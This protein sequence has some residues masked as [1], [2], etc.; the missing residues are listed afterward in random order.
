MREQAHRSIFCLSALLLASWGCTGQPLS[1][2]AQA[3][4]TILIPLSVDALADLTLSLEHVGYG[5]SPGVPGGYKDPQRGY[6]E[7]RLEQT[8]DVLVTRRAFLTEHTLGSSLAELRTSVGRTLI[9][10]VDIPIDAPHGRFDLELWHRRWNPEAGGGAGVWEENRALAG[11]T[12]YFGTLAILPDVLTVNGETI[13][14]APTPALYASGDG[15]EYSNAY[16]NLDSAVP[17]PSIEI[18]IQDS[19]GSSPPATPWVSSAKVS[20]SYPA[21]EI[22]ILDVVPVEPERGRVFYWDNPARG[23]LH[24]EAMA[25]SPIVNATTNTWFNADELQMSPIRVVFEP[26]NPGVALLDLIDVDATLDVARD[27][28]GTDLLDHGRNISAEAK[29]I[30]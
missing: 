22:K 6:L 14:G 16:L 21:S 13:T 1:L 25:T 11:A 23:K 4:S 30:R 19:P 28:T 10:V 9:L 27:E 8:G 3:G 20:V 29:W 2:S 24:I 15:S 7:V 5:A 26:K 17:R 12:P 18:W